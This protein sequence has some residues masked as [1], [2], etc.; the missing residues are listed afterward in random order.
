MNPP[1]KTP[2][3]LSV[4]LVSCLPS[5]WAGEEEPRQTMVA[6]QTAPVVRADLH[7]TV[8]L[9]G[10]V[11]PAPARNGGTSAGARL[12]ATTP[13]V[14]AAV[15]CH[16][17]QKVKK[18]DILFR[19]DSRVVD[20]ERDFARKNLDRQKKLLPIGGASEKSVQ[21]AEAQLGSAEARGMLLRVEAPFDGVVTR[22]N[23]QPGEAVETTTVLGEI[24][25]PSRLVVTAAVPARE[26]AGVV[27]GMPVEF[28]IDGKLSPHPG[29]VEFVSPDI[30]PATNS[31]LAR[32]SVAPDSGLRAGEFI[33]V[34]VISEARPGVLAVPKS[35]VYTAPDGI[36]TL[37]IVKD[38]KAVRKEVKTGLHDGD[39]VEIFGDD[40]SEG[41]TVVTV[42]SYALPD[43]A[44][45]RV[46]NPETKQP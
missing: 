1:M 13:G 39:L 3:I 40:L 42:G 5:A 31:L 35:S 33:Q 12:S 38:N 8:T 34:R 30:D 19:L 18:G 4:A 46:V 37:S 9:Y 16:E 29:A 28:L 17:G 24:L 41:Q 43:G 23:V 21:E 27:A 36:T 25:D 32:L 15:E 26:A 44:G 10:S 45:V 22:I 20:V 14:L 2:L 7:R 6:V 11:V